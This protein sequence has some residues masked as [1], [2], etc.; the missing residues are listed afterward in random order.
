M[1]DF[2]PIP[3]KQSYVKLFRQKSQAYHASSLM[4]S[5]IFTPQSTLLVS[6]IT[7]NHYK[8]RHI[9][10]AL[11]HI[12]AIRIMRTTLSG[13]GRLYSLFQQHPLSIYAHIFVYDIK[14]GTIC[15]MKLNTYALTIISYW[16]IEWR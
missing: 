12:C 3:H 6:I 10:Y 13:S 7:H 5:V 11:Y 4:S 9:I 2:H 16:D 15:D 8:Y 14:N 1:F